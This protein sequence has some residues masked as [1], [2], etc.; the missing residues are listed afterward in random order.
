MIVQIVRFK[1]NLSDEKVVEI[2]NER[3]PHYRAL[4][5]LIQKYY[6]RYPATGEYGAVYVWKSEE[7]MKEFRDSEL[8]RTISGAYQIQGT[9]DLTIAEVAETLR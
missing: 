5:D 8:G 2:S 3:A 4:K 1:T 9:L 7:A 6:L